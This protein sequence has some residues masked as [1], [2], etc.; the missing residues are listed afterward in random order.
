MRPIHL[1]YYE[2]FRLEGKSEYAS[3]LNASPVG[4]ISLRPNA[5][6]SGSPTEGFYLEITLIIIHIL[7][8]INLYVLILIGKCMLE[9][10]KISIL[11]I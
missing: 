8:S 3:L 10:K 4:L 2:S 7:I 11:K 5:R 9:E 6:S 1:W